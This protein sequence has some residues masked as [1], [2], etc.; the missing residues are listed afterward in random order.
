[1]VV[2]AGAKSG[3]LVTASWALEQGRECFVVP[4]SIDAPTSAGCNG[5][6]RAWPGLARVVSGVPQLLEDLGMA[7]EAGLATPPVPRT[8][9]SGAPAA[10]ADSLDPTAALAAMDGADRPIASAI[11]GGAATVDE[12]VAVTRQPIGAVLRALTRVEGDGFIIGRHGRYRVSDT[13]AGAPL[14]PVSEPAA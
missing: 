6:L 5:F 11:L 9:R 2:E 10:T 3:A 12:I 14:R 8:A 7:A 13:Y 4:G 1:V